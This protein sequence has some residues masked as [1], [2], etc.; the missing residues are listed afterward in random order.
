MGR[1]RADAH[2]GDV[3]GEG[4]AR[5]LVQVGDV[6]R[7]VPGRVGDA[8]AL[9]GLATAED[10][11]VLLRHGDGLAPHAVHVLLAVEPPGAAQQLG[12][13]DE[14]WR[15]ELVHVDAQVGERPHERAGRPGV[16]EVDVGE[17]QRAWLAV[18]DRVHE[19][20]DRG[21]GPG[22]DEHVAGLPAA[23]HA[24]V[25]EVVQ[26]DLAH[27]QHATRRWAVQRVRAGFCTRT[28]KRRVMCPRMRGRGVALLLVTAALVLAVRRL[29]EREDALAV[30]ARDER[31]LLHAAADDDDALAHRR[32]A[33]HRRRPSA[34]RTRSTTASTSTR[35]SPTRRRSTA[36]F[37]IDPEINS[38]VLYQAA[39]YTQHCRLFAPVYRQLTLQ[40]I[41]LGGGS[42]SN[43]PVPADRLHRRARRLARLP[44]ALQ[45]RPAGRPARP[46][47]G[48]DHP[49]PARGKRD[50]PQAEG[51]QPPGLRRAARRQ[52]A[53]APGAGRRRRLQAHPRLPLAAANSAAWSPTRPS[54][55]PCRRTRS[56]AA[57]PTPGDEVLCTDPAALGGGDGAA[58]DLDLSHRAR[59]RRA[60]RSASRSP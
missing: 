11:D 2:A 30:Q 45:R 49:A 12:G 25:A 53:R 32:R 22:V 15:A 1:S 41:G 20:G 13:V 54:T 42:A 28:V 10:R 46:L 37:A 4:P 56:S 48:L 43:T 52:R 9:D 58:P 24:V 23:D 21:L 3:A 59:S 50:R 7:G 26:V 60:R 40:G 31:V 19:R 57:R 5:V 29:R 55:A 18:R 34:T 35:R 36:N 51:P 38:I 44:E 39:R 47:A 6:V 27:P 33:R 17:Q 14:V 16:V 8:E